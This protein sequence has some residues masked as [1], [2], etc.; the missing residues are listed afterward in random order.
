MN[1]FGTEVLNIYLFIY[2]LQY[3]FHTHTHTHIYIIYFFGERTL[4]FEI[5]GNKI[6]PKI[7]NFKNNFI[8]AKSIHLPWCWSFG[9][10]QTKTWN[11]KEYNTLDFEKK[12]HIK[13]IP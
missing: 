4:K 8:S 2:V 1:G 6:S 5:V 9:G 11:V 10:R 7:S 12:N 3:N 13:K